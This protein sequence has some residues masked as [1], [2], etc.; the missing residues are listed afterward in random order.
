[1]AESPIS[2][3]IAG[4]DALDP[5]VIVLSTFIGQSMLINANPSF[6]HSGALFAKYFERYKGFSVNDSGS[7]EHAKSL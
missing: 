4:G 1:M 3:T 7:T 6:G 2:R 5:D